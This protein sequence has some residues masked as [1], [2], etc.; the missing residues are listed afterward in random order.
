MKIGHARDRTEMRPRWGRD[1]A[2][3]EG[4]DLEGSRVGSLG[5]VQ[6]LH[7]FHQLAV[8]H[9]AISVEIE[10]AEGL[11]DRQLRVLN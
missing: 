2:E 11:A 4:A 6:L 8:R 1:R 5:D 9:H 10:L 3:H 7:R